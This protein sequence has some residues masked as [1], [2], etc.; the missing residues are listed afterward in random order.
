[1]SG[2]CVVFPDATATMAAHY[3]DAGRKIL[4]DLAVTIGAPT[5]FG[6]AQA[7]RDADGAILF[8]TK[9]GDA[10][11]ADCQ[12]LRAVV[13]LSTG[14]G[15]WVD[16]DAA[17]RRGIAVRNVRGYAD[18]T[19]AE[20]ALA[21]IFACARRVAEMDRALRAGRWNPVAHSE[22]AG[23]TLAIIGLGGIGRALAP[24]AATLG[25]RV[26]G[27]N[28]GPVPPGLAVE[29]LPLDAAL[30]R[31]D[32]VSLHLALNEETRGIISAERL[33][34]LKPGAVLINTARG[35]LIDEPAL[36]A[37]LQAGHLAAAGL[38]VFASEPLGPDHPLTRLDT[39]T[40]TAHAAW[41][42]PESGRRLLHRGLE[43]LRDVMED[44]KAPL[45]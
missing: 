35:A 41:L 18:R 32:I 8:Q 45:D 29:P 20:H 37:V 11:M 31:A 14:I 26:V 5:S 33:A 34:R 42:S 43:E 39:V 21:L 36:V 10:V 24:L 38:D 19:V 6:L 9:L 40:L 13:F 22:L 2:R 12:R 7:L 17:A 23:K 1:M 25:M 16:L 30:A 15:S 3:D 44:T 4:P 27:W 28:R